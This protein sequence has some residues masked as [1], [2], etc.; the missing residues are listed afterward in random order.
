MKPIHVIMFLENAF[1]LK[2]REVYNI[3]TFSLVFVQTK[4]ISVDIWPNVS[5]LIMYKF[6]VCFSKK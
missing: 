6:Y 3:N 4:L 1:D 5:S 2:K